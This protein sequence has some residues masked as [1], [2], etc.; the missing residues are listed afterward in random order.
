[1]SLHNVPYILYVSILSPFRCEHLGNVP[2]PKG[3]Y[4][5][6]YGF[7][8][9]HDAQLALPPIY[10]EKIFS[11]NPKIYL[12]LNFQIDL[13]KVC[14]SHNDICDSLKNKWPEEKKMAQLLQSHKLTE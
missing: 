11:E 6:N 1:M 12:E 9:G 13:E 4:T 14:D 5:P 7:L 8:T 2:S 3:D 10:F